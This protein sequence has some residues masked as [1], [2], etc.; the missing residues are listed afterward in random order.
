VKAFGTSGAMAVSDSIWILDRLGSRLIHSQERLPSFSLFDSVEPIRSQI[1]P[2]FHFAVGPKD[3][4]S[5]D[6]V[7]A[8]EAK[9]NAKII[10]REITSTA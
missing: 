8:A 2:Y 6:V 3:L 7:L 1:G 5:I 9:V 4:N 10:L